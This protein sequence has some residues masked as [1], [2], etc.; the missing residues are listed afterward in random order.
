VLLWPATKRELTSR[1]TWSKLDH[2][3]MKQTFTTF[4]IIKAL[5]I[6]RE[7]LR[8]WLDRGLVRP[9]IERSE[10][11][12]TRNIFS[13]WDVYGIA[14]FK[15]LLERGVSRTQAARLAAAF[16]GG[17]GVSP[18]AFVH[19]VGCRFVIFERT[20]KPEGGDE[21]K[22]RFL[23]SDKWSVTGD[24]IRPWDDALIVNF[25]KL[26]REVDQRLAAL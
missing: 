10:G 15:Q 8:Q 19:A 13:R 3:A 2:R 24:D 23:G 20:A 9:S 14:L 16:M 25:A 11:R 17:A 1:V 26:Q 6:D 18:A 4:D 21:M 7:R 5:G 22:A 12:G